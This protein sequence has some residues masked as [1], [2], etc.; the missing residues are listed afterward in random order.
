MKKLIGIVVGTL[1]LFTATA[2]ATDVV[3]QDGKEYNIKVQGEGNLS[4]SNHIIGPNGTLYGLCGYS[5]CSFEIA[6]HKVNAERGA[7]LIISGG[8]FVQ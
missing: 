6:G 8:K 5:F 3:N 4:I 7:R 1:F 2:Q